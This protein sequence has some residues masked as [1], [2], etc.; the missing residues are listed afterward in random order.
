MKKLFK[1]T[2]IVF[3]FLFLSSFV[4]N[5]V[6]ADVIKW[7]YIDLVGQEHLFETEPECNDALRVAVGAQSGI[8][9]QTTI[10]GNPLP[11]DGPIIISGKT[12]DSKN[13][14]IYTL[15]APIGNLVQAPD[16]VGDYF[17]IIF[18]IAIGF[19][20]V[21]A[22]VMIVIGGVQYMGDESIFGKT[23]AKSR[24][25]SAI[26]GLLIALGSYALLNTINPDL[27]GSGGVHISQV[28]AE[29]DE[30]TTPWSEYQSGDNK[31]ACPSGFTDV[32]VDGAVPNKINICSS[33][34]SKLLNM[35]NAAKKDG[36]II[37]GYGSRS[38]KSQE[39][40]RAQNCGGQD[41]IYNKN[42]VCKPKTAIPGTSNHEKGLAVDFNCNGKTMEQAGG[43][44]SVCYKWLE[45]H[46]SEYGFKNN[47]S[48]L[49][50]SWHWSTGP[51]AGY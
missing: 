29:I 4:L 48:S 51:K 23:E 50:E 32:P 18:K 38:T 24:I 17:N 28:T 39:Q 5:F 33:V 30:E 1:I 43:V 20:G 21:L 46:A 34:A 7:K 19:C 16:N 41:N 44:N 49:K 27:L 31:N 12:D 35:I 3:V 9:I 10:A 40:K 42:A 26:F 11:P 13:S 36:V 37:S 47:Y 22:V 14:G 15:L 45:L 25:T 8:C 2:S 6:Y